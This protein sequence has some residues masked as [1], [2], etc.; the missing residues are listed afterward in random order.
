MKEEINL[1]TINGLKRVVEKL[2]E[3]VSKLEGNSMIKVSD[4]TSA[5]NESLLEQEGRF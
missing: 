5:F 1:I 4:L 3:D 2:N